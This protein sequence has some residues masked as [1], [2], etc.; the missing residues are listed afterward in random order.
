M[1]L[2]HVWTHFLVRASDTSRELC[3]FS[4]SSSVVSIMKLSSF[5]TVQLQMADNR[6]EDKR[7]HRGERLM[8]CCFHSYYHCHQNKQI[9]CERESA[10]MNTMNNVHTTITTNTLSPRT[11][12][13]VNHVFINM[14]TSFMSAAFVWS[15][16]TIWPI[17]AEEA[18]VY[19]TQRQSKK[20]KTKK[21][22]EETSWQHWLLI[23]GFIF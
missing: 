10:A 23:A 22:D 15:L 20:R 17:T 4:P 9:I 14:L 3:H 7:R 5:Q 21:R 13:H 1:E 2:L 16:F 8:I 11:D 18:G 19:K 12:E 6:E